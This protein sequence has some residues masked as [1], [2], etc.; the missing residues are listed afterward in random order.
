MVL[1]VV[2]LYVIKY[3]KLLSLIELQVINLLNKF[4]IVIN[5]KTY[6]I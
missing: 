4:T 5:K 1:N 3:F 6:H 2:S